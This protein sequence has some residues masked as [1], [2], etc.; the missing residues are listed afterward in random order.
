MSPA[1][2]RLRCGCW[3]RNSSSQT[4][5]IVWHHAAAGDGGGDKG[6]LTEVLVLPQ[7]TVQSKKVAYCA[8]YSHNVP[9]R[10]CW[11]PSSSVSVC[12]A[13]ET[14]NKGRL[15][16][17]E[18]VIVTLTLLCQADKSS[19]SVSW[20]EWSVCLAKSTEHSSES[21]NTPCSGH[22]HLLQLGG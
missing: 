15:G 18:L 20:I 11:T 8:M 19:A 14:K 4:V 12:V 17:G 2:D 3:S 16:S 13:T 6:P 7:T 22:F 10:W 5:F 21:H 9:H 1:F